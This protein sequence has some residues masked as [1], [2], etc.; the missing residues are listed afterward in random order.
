MIIIR[1]GSNNFTKIMG[2][3]RDS[4]SW[5]KETNLLNQKVNKNLNWLTLE[6]DI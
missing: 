1:I 5:P 4:S 6:K 3:S 2:V